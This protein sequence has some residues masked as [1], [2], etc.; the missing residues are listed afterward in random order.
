MEVLVTIGGMTKAER[1]G[2]V[3]FRFSLCELG[4]RVFTRHGI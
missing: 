2:R 1:V 4:S 3:F